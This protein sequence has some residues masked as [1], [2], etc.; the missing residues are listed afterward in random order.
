[1]PGLDFVAGSTA[2]EQ[3]VAQFLDPAVSARL[4]VVPGADA[5]VVTA[6]VDNV[7]VGHAWPSGATQNRRAWLEI[8]AYVGGV[9]VYSSGSV[10]DGESVTASLNAPA[11]IFREQ[12]YDALGEPTL[13]MWNAQTARTELLVPATGN[14]P[15]GS[16][17]TATARV[18][19]QVDRVTA[20]VRVRPIDYD[21]IDALIASGD[22]PASERASV[23]TLTVA[24]TNLE[25]TADRG[26]ACLP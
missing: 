21:V 13:F 24:A 23:A 18:A 22:L 7:L 26:P 5:A 2:Q 10:R 20:V 1:M 14:D 15:G 17:R 25:W 11:L 9:A 19:A 8:V 12:L 6:K 4:C 16:T 3:L